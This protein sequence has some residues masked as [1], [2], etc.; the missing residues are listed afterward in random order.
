[1]GMDEREASQLNEMI[2]VG[3]DGKIGEPILSENEAFNDDE[4]EK[5]FET[6]FNAAL[7]SIIVG[8]ELPNKMY[9][10][11]INNEFCDVSAT[12]KLLHGLGDGAMKS[13]VQTALELFTQNQQISDDDRSPKKMKTN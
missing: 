6:K 8:I 12:E 11:T 10:E 5:P 1:M 4:P 2:L 3:K 7:P 9:R 13:G